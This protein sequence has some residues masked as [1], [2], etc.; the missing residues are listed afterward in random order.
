[1][2]KFSADQGALQRKQQLSFPAIT[3]QEYNKEC[4]ENPRLQNPLTGRG[5]R[6]GAAEEMGRCAVSRGFRMESFHIGTCIEVSLSN[7]ITDSE[8]KIRPMA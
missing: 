7:G 5:F 6:M 8:S 3:I 1:M 4:S 2:L